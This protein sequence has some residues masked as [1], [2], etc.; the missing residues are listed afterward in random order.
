MLI[1]ALSIGVN[2]ALI[3]VIVLLVLAHHAALGKLGS[4]MTAQIASHERQVQW[5]VTQLGLSQPAG[6][7]PGIPPVVPPPSAYT[8]PKV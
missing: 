5:L 8:P 6:P 4:L 1:E 7:S 3:V 2:I